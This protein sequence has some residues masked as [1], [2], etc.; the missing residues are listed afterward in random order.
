MSEPRIRP[1][2]GTEGTRRRVDGGSEEYEAT[3]A[4]AAKGLVFIEGL[5]MRGNPVRYAELAW[6]VL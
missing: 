1:D 6:M 5:H 4:F 3:R 2:V